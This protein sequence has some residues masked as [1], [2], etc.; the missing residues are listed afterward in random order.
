M[1]TAKAIFENMLA[2]DLS[3]C[4]V[5]VCLA[6]ALK[7][8][9]RPRIERLLLST[10]L[11]ETFRSI[12]SFT[13]ARYKRD[14]SNSDLLLHRYAL[15]SKPDTHEVEYLDVSAYESIAGQIEPL[16]TLADLEI[17]E[18]DEKFVAGMRFYVIVAQPPEG[19]AVYFFRAYSPK[20]MLSRSRSF[21]MIFSNG[22]YDRVSDPMFL[23]DH[24]IDC[25]YQ[26]GMMFLFKK[27]HFHEMFRF[28]EMVRKVASETLET[29]RIAVPIHNFETFVKDC[30]ANMAKQIK[31]NHIASK[32]Y[33]ERLTIDNI[34][35][36]IVKNNLS[37]SIIKDGNKEMIV[38]DHTNK[39]VLLKLLDDDYLWSLMT[40]QSYEV[41]GKRDVSER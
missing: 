13:Q 19:D 3:T 14:Y 7:D 23:F 33:L 2:L 34:K 8:E 12:V 1:T 16:V 4:E 27:E 38:Y 32:P 36:V 41:S 20:K 31:L 18:A 30:E 6:S 22:I 26:D 24:M 40:E 25:V 11:V 15:Q 29:I 37:V 21:A 35:K 17:F 39:W 28:F 9:S 10:E 5:T